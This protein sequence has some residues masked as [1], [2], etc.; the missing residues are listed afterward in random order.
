MKNGR[1]AYINTISF[2]TSGLLGLLLVANQTLFQTVCDYLK[3]ED[4]SVWI[5]FFSSAFFIGM[6]AVAIVSG[7]MAERI[8]KKNVISIFSFVVLGG[9]LVLAFCEAPVAALIGFLMVGMGF[10]AVEGL[11]NGVVVDEN[12]GS[13]SSILNRTFVFFSAGAIL[14]PLTIGNFIENGGD[15]HYIYYVTAALYAALG[16]LFLF[17]KT[18]KLPAAKKKKGMVSFSL[19]KNKFFLLPCIMIFIYLG[20]EAGATNWTPNIFASTAL[21]SY[22]LAAFWAATGISRLVLSFIKNYDLHK[23]LTLHSILAAA[24]FAGIPI[25]NQYTAVCLVFF[26]LVGYGLGPLWPSYFSLGTDASGEFTGAGSGLVM[27]F[28]SLGGAVL[29]L[30]VGMFTGF[31]IMWLCMAFVAAALILQRV[32]VS[33]KKKEIK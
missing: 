29:S 22:A 4:A 3:I 9:S 16:I 17:A 6:V 21:G 20:A 25:F 14:S 1:L 27:F 10:G 13:S 24:G 8:G 2:L 26:A 11:I 15:W 33:L 5:G 30:V 18:T 19:L 31:E 32:F 23:T 7:E 28:S 12:R